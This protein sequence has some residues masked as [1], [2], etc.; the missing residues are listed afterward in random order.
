VYLLFLVLAMPIAVA[1]YCFPGASTRCTK[2]L[3][4]APSSWLWEVQSSLRDTGAFA[5]VDTFNCG[6][7]TPSPAELGAYDAILVFGD[8]IFADAALLGDRLAAYHDQGGGVVLVMASD[9]AGAYGTVDNGY[10]LMYYQTGYDTGYEQESLVVVEAQSPLM[11]GVASLT[12]PFGWRSTANVVA[13]RAVVVARWRYGEHPLVLRGTRGNR[14]L[15][16]LNMFPTSSRGMYQGWSGDGGSLMRNA[17]MFSR[18]MPCATGTYA[19]AGEQGRRVGGREPE[20]VWPDAF[21]GVRRDL[22]IEQN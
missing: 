17:L 12:A 14:T 5:T 4:L 22:I 8:G 3:I 7:V 18:C 10:A 19:G 20:P 11:T 21:D 1:Q 6:S 9:V 13:G 15:V 16:E 2:V